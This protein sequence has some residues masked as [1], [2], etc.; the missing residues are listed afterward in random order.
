MAASPEY[1]QPEPQA[2]K[3]ESSQ[4]EVEIKSTK[5]EDLAVNMS[6]GYDPTNVFHNYLAN[7]L[8]NKTE[9]FTFYRISQM[10]EDEM[11]SLALMLIKGTIRTKAKIRV[12]AS[13]KGSEKEIGGEKEEVQMADDEGDDPSQKFNLG[14]SNAP[15]KKKPPFGEEEGFGEEKKPNKYIQYLTQC[16]DVFNDNLGM[17]LDAL[18]WGYACRE[19]VYEMDDDLGVAIPVGFRY[20]HPYDIRP[21]VKNNKIVGA[22]FTHKTTTDQYAYIGGPKKFW[23]TINP[24]KNPFFGRSVLKSAHDAFQEKY[25]KYGYLN[26]RRVWFGKNAMSGGMIKFP[27]GRTYDPATRQEIDN[28]V[29]A[30]RLA[31]M[32]YSG[33]VMVA[34]QPASKDVPG[35]EFEPPDIKVIPQLMLD[36][37][38]E[39]DMRITR[40]MGIPHEVIFSQSEGLG[41]TSGRVIPLMAFY[42]TLVDYLHWMVQ[43]YIDQVVIP[44]MLINFPELKKKDIKIKFE[45]G[46]FEISDPDNP[47]MGDQEFGDGDGDGIPNEDETT[48]DEEVENNDSGKRK[49]PGGKAR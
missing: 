29:H 21:A 49:V 5:P 35:W 1:E 33:R 34:Q 25:R 14:D 47:T 3:P 8:L 13:I 32:A 40:G 24:T 16:M 17:N 42:D 26:F 19:V 41:S 7:V 45:V 39:I 46:G 6:R 12:A 48:E 20:I 37:G 43:P 23:I 36:Y 10:L 31:A 28:R 15:P 22:V 9:P 27:A 18:E 11:V 2:D 30:E 38:T 4:P 44:S